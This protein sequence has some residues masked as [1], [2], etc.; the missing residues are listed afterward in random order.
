VRLLW[1]CRSWSHFYCVFMIVTIWDLGCFLLFVFERFYSFV[2]VDVKSVVDTVR[3]RSRLPVFMLPPIQYDNK[4]RLI[5][6]SQDSCVL[7]VF[8]LKF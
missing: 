4:N 5:C 7:S 6:W 2:E 1:W 3:Y 8:C